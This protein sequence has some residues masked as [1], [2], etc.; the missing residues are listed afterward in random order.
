M[1]IK[2]KGE[3]KCTAYFHMNLHK[4]LAIKLRWNE[5]DC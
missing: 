5:G 2:K 1:E 3:V 4:P